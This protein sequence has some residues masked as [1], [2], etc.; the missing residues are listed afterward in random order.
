MLHIVHT[1]TIVYVQVFAQETG[2]EIKY[3]VT[4]CD[5][6]HKLY[7]IV[8]LFGYKISLHLAAVIL[9]FK[10]KK[11]EVEKINKLCQCTYNII[12]FQVKV[13]NDSREI[14]LILYLTGLVLA[15]VIVMTF[16]FDSYLNIYN[17]T[18]AIGI[19]ITNAVILCVVFVSKVINYI[20][21]FT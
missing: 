14:V 5:A 16:V 4:L 19:C 9:T 8:I 13:L 7:W 18:Y 15:A 2:I 10:I 1:S 6:S 3:T 11:V 21:F 12:I 17:G 20:W